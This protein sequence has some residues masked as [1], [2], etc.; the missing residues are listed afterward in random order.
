MR[1]QRG[2][3]ALHERTHTKVRLAMAIASPAGGADQLG[4]SVY[5]AAPR[6]TR[7]ISV[8]LTQPAQD[9]VLDWGERRFPTALDPPARSARAHPYD[10]RYHGGSDS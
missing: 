10:C 5:G 4:S 8:G 1:Q 3:G 6:V 7:S 9:C 2:Q